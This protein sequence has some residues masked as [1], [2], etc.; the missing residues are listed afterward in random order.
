MLFSSVKAFDIL[1]VRLHGKESRVLV[2]E[3]LFQRKRFLEGGHVNPITQQKTVGAITELYGRMEFP[4][5]R[6][7]ANSAGEIRDELDKVM[8][9]KGE[10]V[11]LKKRNSRYVPNSRECIWLKV[12]WLT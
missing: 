10:G 12:S 8:E 5:R 2:D 7:E 1:Y 4:Y 11:I 6:E 9:R 3:P